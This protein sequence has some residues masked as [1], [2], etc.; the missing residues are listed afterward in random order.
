MRYKHDMYNIYFT[1]TKKALPRL[2][3]KE[4]QKDEMYFKLINKL[5]K[6]HLPNNSKSFLSYISIL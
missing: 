4:C 3:I 5:Y 1:L 6:K 2:N